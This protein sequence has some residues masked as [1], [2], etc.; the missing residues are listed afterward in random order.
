MLV[1]PNR[2]T[3]RSQIRVQHILQEDRAHYRQILQTT[4]PTP[5]QE[6]CKAERHYANKSD[7][8]PYDLN[9]SSLTASDLQG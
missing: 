9:A 2:L 1:A 6:K 4:P 7:H 3:K 8:L 5:T